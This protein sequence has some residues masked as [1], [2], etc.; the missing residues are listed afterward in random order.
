MS[1][2]VAAAIGEKRETFLR[3]T[4]ETYEAPPRRRGCPGDSFGGEDRRDH[5]DDVPLDP[6]ALRPTGGRAP[7]MAQER[8]QGAGKATCQPVAR[9]IG[10]R[11]RDRQARSE[12]SGGKR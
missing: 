1:A 10:H 9:L 11:N 8:E 6:E 5:A 7:G 2:D 12:V 4:V 3:A